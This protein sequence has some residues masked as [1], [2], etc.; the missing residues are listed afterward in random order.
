[1]TARSIR[2]L[3]IFCGVGGSSA[4]A[5]AAGAEICVAIDMC[6]IAT[7]T[8]KDN[9][10][11]T[12]VLTSR[13]ED[14]DPSELKATL[15]QIDILIASPECTNHTCAKGSA[16]RS[17]ASRSTAFQVVRF[18]KD[19]KAR[20]VVVENVPH[21]QTWKRYT[22]WLD[23]LRKLGYHIREQVLNAADFG[24]PQGRRRLF[25]MCDLDKR[26]EVVRPRIRS[27]KSASTI[28]SPN[29]AFA[30]SPLYAVGRAQ[31]TLQRAE[32]AIASVG[33]HKPFLLV[34]YGSDAAGG[35]QRLDVPLRTVTTLDRFAL[36]RR[37][38]RGHEMRML[39]V[40]ELKKAMGFPASYRLKY[41]TRRDK[42]RLLGNAVSP[43]VM[44]AV[45]RTLTHS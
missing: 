28:L 41:G 13:L 32:R 4:G 15:G 8:Y 31:P 1:M 33:T 38:T 27:R 35:W 44:T 24:V 12:T 6:P 45:I 42:I 34:Y 26:P 30:F 14:V 10:K 40:P 16:P 37:T 36:V 43:P 23:E 3:D 2:G 20:W 18:A 21:M 29:D 25:V 5:S 39:Q 22:V 7:A 19:I 11:N 17:E 9:S